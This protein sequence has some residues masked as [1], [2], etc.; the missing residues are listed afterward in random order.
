MET[1]NHKPAPGFLRK[2]LFIITPC[3]LILTFTPS[4]QEDLPGYCRP[5]WSDPGQI[6]TQKRGFPPDASIF[7]DNHQSTCAIRRPPG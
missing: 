6:V 1:K 2:I 5:E 7:C 3:L 4:C